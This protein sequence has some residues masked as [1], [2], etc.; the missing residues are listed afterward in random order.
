MHKSAGAFL[1]PIAKRAT[2]SMRDNLAAVLLRVHPLRQSSL[3]TILVHTLDDGSHCGI[4]Q[5]LAID[6]DEDILA[7]VRQIGQPR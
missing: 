4:A 3:F 1:D 6:A 7:D 5:R 2:E